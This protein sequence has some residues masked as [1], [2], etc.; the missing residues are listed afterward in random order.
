[1]NHPI[2]IIILVAL[3]AMIGYLIWLSMQPSPV[4]STGKYHVELYDSASGT[5]DAQLK[6]LPFQPQQIED[7]TVGSSTYLRTEW[8]QAEQT[9]NHFLITISD[10]ASDFSRTESGEHDRVSLDLSD[11]TSDT[12]YI[13][14]LRA[15]LEPICDTWLVSDQEYSGRTPIEYFDQENVLIN[16]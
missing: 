15:C 13:I 8:S 14:V 4:D 11:L 5:F 6:I 16:P 10:P 2:R 12:E 1:M 3:S 7:A 9:Y